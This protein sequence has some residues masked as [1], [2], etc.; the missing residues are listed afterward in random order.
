MK[1]ELSSVDLHFLIQELKSIEGGLLG[2]T[3]SSDK[4]KIFIQIY[5]KD[6]GKKF[7]TYQHPFIWLGLKKPAGKLS[8]FATFLRKYYERA[9]IVSIKQVGSERII[10]LI[11]Q[12]EKTAKI[13]LELFGQGNMIICDENNLILYPL[14]VQEWK[15]RLIKKG[16]KYDWFKKNK[17]CFEQTEKDFRNLE[18]KETFLKR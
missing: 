11:I 12:K 14:E 15:D 4:K 10:E 9:K 16:E 3:Y 2:K 6:L 17:N 13:F 5:Q 7:L 18:I 1:Q 8:N